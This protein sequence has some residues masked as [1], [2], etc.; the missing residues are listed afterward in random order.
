MDVK[1]YFSGKHKMY[2]YKIE[3]SVSPAGAYVMMSTHRPDSVSDMSIFLERVAMHRQA[4]KKSKE[5]EKA[6]DLGEGSTNFPRSWAI[7]MDKGY[8]GVD[9]AIRSIRPKKKPI[10]SNLDRMDLERNLR[11]S[12][13][14]VN[15]ENAFGRTCSLWM[16]SYV[17]F[18]WSESKYDRIQR[19]CFALTNFHTSLHPLRRDDSEF[20][21]SV[22]ARYCSMSE[23]LT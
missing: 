2:G 4:V 14:R 18:K 3:A 17:T 6:V 5:E 8:E 11:V 20:Y 21:K 9:D 13:D 7:L 15:V 10:A 22:L 12:S 1:R 23:E 19:L 16:A